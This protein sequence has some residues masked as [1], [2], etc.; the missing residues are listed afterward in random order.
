[1]GIQNIQFGSITFEIS[2]ANI[3]VGKGN[4]LLYLVKVQVWINNF[5]NFLCKY[6]CW[7]R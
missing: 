4:T 2:S 6:Q 5:W 1:L 7:K 3:S